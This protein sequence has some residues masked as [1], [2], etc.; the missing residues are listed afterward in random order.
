[1]QRH[2][3][4]IC[5]TYWV[6]MY[7]YMFWVLLINIRLG[8]FLRSRASKWCHRC[9]ENSIHWDELS[10]FVDDMCK[11]LHDIE[12]HSCPLWM[13]HTIHM[14][15][16]CIRIRICIYI[17]IYIYIHNITHQSICQASMYTYIYNLP[18]AA[19]IRIP[20]PKALGG[21]GS[22][23]GVYLETMS[24]SWDF[25]PANILPTTSYYLS[26]LISWTFMWTKPS[27]II[28]LWKI[29]WVPNLGEIR[30]WNINNK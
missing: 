5:K 20:Y 25:Y 7:M 12:F 24:R 1:M 8:E 26:H 3:V 4:D 15:N 9:I 30:G 6:I 29:F 11:Y 16:V 13:M 14:H 18:C 22:V 21:S 10:W 2:H 27:S 17:Y 23:V 28:K 19:T